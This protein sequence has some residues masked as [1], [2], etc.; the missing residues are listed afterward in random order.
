MG[1]Y[2]QTW[3]NDFL[4]KRLTQQYSNISLGANSALNTEI[5]N[6]KSLMKRLTL[7]LWFA[8]QLENIYTFNIVN[9]S[10]RNTLPDKFY[11]DYVG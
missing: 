5:E 1:D 11:L 8:P 4:M 10:T 6:T 3:Y 9:A 2:G 7:Y